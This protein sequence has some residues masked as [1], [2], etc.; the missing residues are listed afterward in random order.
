MP[1]RNTVCVNPVMSP[2]N[3]YFLR[4]SNFEYGTEHR[5][6]DVRGATAALYRSGTVSVFIAHVRPRPLD[7]A[8]TMALL[9][10]HCDRRRRPWR[11]QMDE[12]ANVCDRLA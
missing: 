4:I 8:A 9:P 6:A 3:L 10:L 7:G 12:Y 1:R 11:R 2:I 5:L